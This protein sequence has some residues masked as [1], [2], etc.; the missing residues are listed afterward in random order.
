VSR[1]T[2]ATPS[3][4]N[5]PKFRAGDRVVRVTESSVPEG[6]KGTVL[7]P[8]GWPFVGKWEVEYD[9]HPCPHPARPG[10]YPWARSQTSWISREE[11]IELTR[12]QVRERIAKG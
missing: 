9:D 6:I 11:A 3:A 4:A 5:E 10:H 1:Q 7:G 12:E 8:A 2:P